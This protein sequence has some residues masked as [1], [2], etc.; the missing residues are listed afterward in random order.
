MI[1]SFYQIEV[2]AK[3][4]DGKR[5]SEMHFI[6]MVV[7]ICSLHRS[8]FILLGL[9]SGFCNRGKRQIK[10]RTILEV[11]G[12]QLFVC[13]IIKC[14]CGTYTGYISLNYMAICIE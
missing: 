7:M 4:V 10:V 11:V 8:S 6:V 1:S 5:D 14:I 2:S 3:L 13:S 12:G 9:L